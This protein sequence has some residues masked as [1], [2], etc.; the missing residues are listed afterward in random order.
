MYY[1]IS[2]VESHYRLHNI[3]FTIAQKVLGTIG[4]SKYELS[5]DKIEYTVV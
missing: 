4:N 1:F 3:Q 5:E 2:Q